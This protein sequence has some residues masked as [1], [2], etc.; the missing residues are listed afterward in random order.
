MLTLALRSTF[1]ALAAGVMFAAWLVSIPIQPLTA[2]VPFSEVLRELQT[3]RS[4]HLEIVKDGTEA[5]VWVQA[6]GL[7]RINDAPQRYRIS[8]GS[9]LWQ[10]DETTNTVTEVDSP[11][12]LAPEQHINLVGLLE[13]GVHDASSL[14]TA[15][16]SGTRDYAGMECH[17]Y[18]VN[19]PAAAGQVRIEALAEV[20]S[21]RLVAMVASRI[22][23][24]AAKQE[25]KE[26]GESG[27]R[28]NITPLAELKLI[29]VNAP[30]NEDQFKVSQSLTE[31]GRIGTIREPQGI[32]TLRPR[33]AQRWTPLCRETAMYPGDWLRTELRGANAVKVVLSS[34]T[35]LTLGP[36]SQ[37]EFLSPQQ[38]R[39][40]SGEVQVSLGTA[41]APFEL[42]APRQAPSRK[43][44]A[45]GKILVRVDRAEQLVDLPQ[46]PHWLTGYEGTS[47]HE[48][49]GSLIVKLPDGRNEPL[50]VG[51]HK[52]TVEIRDQ[53]A[54]TTIEES[55]V[56]HTIGRLEGVFHFPL[57]QDASI[58][59][60]GMWIGNDLI[61]A[62]VV[63]KQ[64]AREIYET[65]LREKRDPGLLEWTGGNLFKA[66]V[67]PIEP[68]SE[69]RVKIV[70][71]QVLPLRGG[72]Y[73]YRYGLR[74]DLLQTKPLRELAIQV[75][76]NSALPLK[77]LHC[78]THTVRSQI[79]AHSGQ[80]EFAAQEY[81]PTR[82]FE[83]VCDVSG[84]QSDVVVIPHQR[85]DDGYL[86]VQVTPPTHEGKLTREVVTDGAPLQ[87]V[88]LCDTSAS[89]DREKRKQQSEFVAT[90]LS[91]LSEKD[92]FS[93]VAADVNPVWLSHEAQLATTENVAQAL[94]FL[95]DRV[96]LGWTD[97]DRAF[98]DVVKK[99][100]SEAHIVYIGDGLVS[101]GDAD[102]VAFVNRLRRIIGGP[103]G[104]QEIDT[105]QCHA[106]TVGNISEAV[107]LKGIADSGRG[108]L[109]HVS[110]EQ[111]PQLV[112]LELM[113]ELAQPGLR[114]LHVEFK[115]IK[116]AAVYPERLPNLASGTQQIIVGRYLPEGKD[117]VG[118]IVVT[119]MRGNEAVRY[120]AKVSLKE[121]ESGNSFI[122]RLWARS[123]LD[124]LL[125]Q[126]STE[127][128]RD[129]VIRLSEEFHII[130]PYTSLLVLE[131]DADRERFG[132][133][134]RYEMGD[135]ERF[136][137]QGRSNANFELLQQQMKIAGNWRQNLRQQVLRRWA[138][139]G[140]YP[141]LLQRQ[142]QQSSSELDSLAISNGTSS[143]GS[144]TAE[145]FWAS[146]DDSPRSRAR[147]SAGIQIAD[148]MGF[149][150]FEMKKE[151]LSGGRGGAMG[152]LGGASAGR[153]MDYDMDHDDLLSLNTRVSE[154]RSLTDG[155]GAW[156]TG[157]QDKSLG[158][159]GEMEVGLRADHTAYDREELDIENQ[160]DFS[161]PASSKAER[162]SDRKSIAAFSRG[163]VRLE[164]S[165][166]AIGVNFYRQVEKPFSRLM[167]AGQTSTPDYSAWM[168][169]LFP[170]LAPPI[171]AS[172]V[173]TADPESWSPEALELS[174]SLLRLNSLQT[175]AGGI[176][177]QHLSE[178]FNPRWSRRES[179][180]QHL[181]L[182]SPTAWL[183]RTLNPGTNVVVDYCNAR[184]RGVY[185]KS[186]LL[187][188][189]RSS[190]K[191]ELATPPLGLY[192]LS[193]SPL[194]ES[195]RH[196][197]A[198]VEPAGEIFVKL[199]L[200]DRGSTSIQHFTIDTA[201]HVLVKHE[202]FDEGRIT[203][204]TTYS[205]FA[206]VAGT[207]WARR[208]IVT[209]AKGQ[210]IGENTWTVRALPA[211]Q[212]QQRIDTELSDLPRVQFI[213]LPA[214]SLKVARQKIAD[215]S[216]EFDDLLRMVIHNASLQLWDELL[217]PIDSIE[218]L[219]D[220]KPGVRWLRPV[221]QSTIRRNEEARTWYLQEARRLAAGRQPDELYLAEFMLG[222]VYP[223]TAWSEYLEFVEVLKPLY[224][225]Q[226]AELNAVATWKDRLVS[227]YD[228]LN[229]T[230]E[231]LSIRRELAVQSPWNLYAQIDFARRLRQAGQVEESLRWLEREQDRRI[232]RTDSEYESL[233]QA[234][235]EYYRAFARW[236]DLL[237]FT[238]QWKDS[239]PE[240]RAAYGEFLSALIYH[241]ELDK[242]NQ[243]VEGWL[244]E[245]QVP[246]QRTPAEEARFQTAL[247]FALAQ[248]PHV[249]I[250]RVQDRWM[251]PL[252]E[253]ARYGL[254]HPQHF[255]VSERIFSNYYF[256]QSDES[257]RLRGEFLRMLQG[258][259][260]KLPPRQLSALVR[261]SISG[262]LEL[263][264]AL[265][266]R[267]QLNANEV[268]AAIWKK[269][270]GA[271]QLRWAGAEDL[272]EKHVLSETLVLIYST[273][274][275]DTDYLPHLRERISSAA[276][277]YRL[278]YIQ[279]LFDALLNVA[280]TAEIEQ[281]AFSRLLE[282]SDAPQAVD[283]LQVLIPALHRFV[284]QMLANRMAA[285]NRQL[286]DQGQTNNFT[287]AELSKKRAEIR[288]AA[289]KG[290]AE[291]LAKSAAELPVTTPAQADVPVPVKP[292]NEQTFSFVDWIRIEQ[293]WLDAQLNQH[294][295]EIIELCWKITGEVPPKVNDA[296]AA[297]AVDTPFPAVQLKQQYFDSLLRQRAFVMLANL[298]VRRPVVPL[299]VD[300]LLKFIDAG[301]Q[302]GGESAA[303]WRFAKFQT[304]VALDRPDDLEVA[305]HDWIRI[306]VS[307]A[308][309]RLL[310]GQ[311]LA[312][313]GKLEEAI[314]LF[315]AC[316]KD[317]LLAAEDYRSL[318]NWYL[319]LDR[320][321]NYERARIEAFKQT[322]ESDLNNLMYQIRN[323]WMQSN[324]PLPSELDENTLFAWK[325][326]FEKTAQPE[327]Y[328]WQLRDLY[329]A[330]RDFRLLQIIPEAV[331]GRT[332]QQ[333]YHFIIQVQSQVL[334]ELRNE[335]TADEII[336][337]IKKLRTGER[338]VVD[339]RALDLLEAVVER[340]SSEVLNQ[341]GPHV[342]ACLAALVRAFQRNWADGEPVQMSKFLRNLGTLH[343][344]KLVEEQLREVRELLK[345]ATPGSREHLQMTDDYCHLLF[346]DYHRKDEALREMEAEIQVYVEKHAGVWPHLD[347]EIL[348]N[349]IRQ[350]EEA[351]RHML[352]EKMLVHYL[353]KSEN[354][355]QK[356]WLQDRLWELYNR[357][358][359]DSGTVSLDTG[360]IL[361]Q[362]LIT[363]FDAEVRQAIDEQVRFQLVTRIVRTMT[364]AHEKKLSTTPD[365]MRRLAFELLPNVL[366]SM[367]AQ[368]RNTAS[369]PMAILREILGP[370]ESLRYVIERM[371]Q[372]PVW[373]DLDWN[374]AWN[375]YSYE[376]AHR[377]HEATVAKLDLKELEPRVLNLALT[378]LRRELRTG[379]NRNRSL[380]HRS[381][382]HFW[383]EKIEDFARVANEIYAEKKTS[384]RR[385]VD[386]ARYLWEGL[387]L[388]PRAVEILFLTHK[389][390]L[391]DVGGR[392]QLISWLH[393]DRRFAESIPLLEPMI[394][395]Y[396]D[397]IS[398]RL[399]LMTAYFQT[400]RPE[401]V[402]Q[403]TEKTDQHFH[404]AGR[405]TESNIT[406]FAKTCQACGMV[407]R[408][409]SYF[410]EAIAL[411]QRQRPGNGLGDLELS[412]LYQDLAR[413]Q[414]A[415][416]RTRE[417]IDA[418]SAAIVCW[419]ARHE[420]RARALETLKHVVASA[421]DLDDYVRF[422]DQE[423]TK[424]GQ[425]SSLLRKVVGQT[426][427]SRSQWDEAIT[428]FKLA[429]TLQPNDKE[430]H[431]ALMACFDAADPVKY[432]GAAVRQLLALIDLERHDLSL[433]QQLAERLK[434][435]EAEAERAA[436]SL[437]EAAPNESENQ[438]AMAE[439]RQKQN[440]WDEA[441]PHWERVANLRKLEPTGLLKLAA[442]QLHQKQWEPA[443]KSI[444]QLQKT[445]WPARFSDVRQVIHNLQQQ[446][447]K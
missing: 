173:A 338:S 235:I 286:Q 22:E 259:I 6:P 167:A 410:N 45:A 95:G 41:P 64:R 325:A 97:L 129:S 168:T 89:M 67:F 237:T 247:N 211:E 23:K 224:E 98:T 261:W 241:N 350:L 294:I 442:T 25:G 206:E 21:N 390:G 372:Y 183:T 122:P 34:N 317:K 422:M 436:T 324:I 315:E 209:D 217:K 322:P 318:A 3:A 51:Y 60:F 190:E 151:M 397:E 69:K 416:S 406:Q 381:Y 287:R 250:Q 117:Q 239:K 15:T 343:H 205:D 134:R 347:N 399:Q 332:P 226:P 258:D 187:G 330:C 196:L 84:N 383:S 336:A 270:A 310:L 215:G 391:L 136:F 435:D 440:R 115:G 208:S 14:L 266:G 430:I 355:A 375:A 191:H 271:I 66:R 90:V 278:Q 344:P 319:V 33:L 192:D 216:A 99:S 58:S 142:I 240:Q 113:Q 73:R 55:F 421:K 53:I 179:R 360:E 427:Q 175:L 83:I 198:R 238:T 5:E 36:G 118:E 225:R 357:A 429:V 373:M 16:P 346:W 57:P 354:S 366:K 185:S 108:S 72:Q 86:L 392:V 102:P 365:T 288:A 133:Q 159:L 54:R 9:R 308:P 405:W 42:L 125:Q 93:L 262:R 420:E 387:N 297:E 432:Q 369:A 111:T 256:A 19:L 150:Q 116:V 264:E 94:K 251:K 156:D 300:R 371:E 291:F 299:N 445:E 327:N 110:G 368:H 351:K 50:T 112:A 7:V 263:S 181:A 160:F 284:D 444:E 329:A 17:V 418:A 71:T 180:N 243:L 246:G 8:A 281:E 202:A 396:P 345:R 56:N 328:L 353:G 144:G 280:W 305:L 267:K 140:R 92:R 260:S 348:G 268:D 194:H 433:Y 285:A 411:H 137:A 231:A 323:R 339:L 149:D 79:T 178:T 88:L 135:G 439:W 63:E 163:T 169:T 103:N 30:V 331:L 76:V 61:E 62:D 195:Y 283:R 204:T 177:V 245:G 147:T 316:E 229:R 378:E 389:D 255:E 18:R 402:Q 26:N 292:L 100:S 200:T 2:A 119:G 221:I 446:L 47:N 132:V 28:L 334:S 203:G 302:A 123:H 307:T 408:A 131:T 87:L 31:D 437:I 68:R 257:D 152:R 70:Y 189:L 234:F 337:H 65:I 301:I 333:A 409:I 431:T 91:S 382:S 128:I 304:L 39:L 207:W 417:S 438:T 201:K 157:P 213:K 290:L 362:N 38:A 46:Q 43:F 233:C 407:D 37:I 35:E 395:E 139:M 313:R 218:K 282:L 244:K 165:K 414:A 352:G 184:D 386:V 230:D 277:E 222:Q 342:D 306:D 424:S 340:K 320:R 219:V 77:Q 326:L 379:E 236:N 426:Y 130:T 298:T 380:Y 447:P 269:I 13:I 296:A 393:L 441:I 85:G 341:P 401:Q 193:L 170:T 75:Q 4:L 174:R 161:R 248:V 153:S 124:H 253:V 434:G 349:H 370:R 52:V 24:H 145:V 109:R 78:P 148:S 80:L 265:N 186:F 273:R 127:S 359:Q 364:I 361:F 415:A 249:S 20:K 1:A 376:L 311:L 74:S 126:G 279:T 384:G 400:Q 228:A 11:W 412:N 374:S 143:S 104:R 32:V 146:L 197:T 312:E 12:F 274:F 254:L 27:E 272:A 155:T 295:P 303:V 29:A 105:R 293:A 403:M 212:Y 276:K 158:D 377:H 154:P 44:N 210:R 48:S 443:R 314:R 425:D 107:V 176:E 171:S 232:E 59:G 413:A 220:N 10:I 141:E 423:S 164:K 321:E 114:D 358:L 388:H 81:T 385:A 172:G 242:A 289:L 96:S 138:F 82:D 188:R 252:G 227:C 394:A 428:Q 309:W 162:A 223:I 101:T 398:Y 363:K 49:L 121:A 419:P 275:S 214:V 356:V 166:L 120:V 106:V 404:K 335:A 182:Y 367:Q 199:I 40:H